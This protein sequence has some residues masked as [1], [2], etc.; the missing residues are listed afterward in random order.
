MVQLGR[1]LMEKYQRAMLMDVSASFNLLEPRSRL[2]PNSSYVFG[3]GAF[4]LAGSQVELL[5]H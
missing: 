5:S 1:P 2:Q 3:A 4:L